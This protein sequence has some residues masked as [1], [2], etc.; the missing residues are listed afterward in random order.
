MLRRRLFFHGSG[1][2]LFGIYIVNV[3]FTLVTLG[4]Y[5]FWGKV[6]VRKYVLSQ[7]EIEGDRFAYHGT[8]RE[9]LIGFLKAMLFFVVPVIVLAVVRD[10]LDVWIGLKGLAGLLGYLL[11][12]VFIPLATVG[13]R[14]YR[15][16][17]SSW[18]GIRFSFRGRARDFVRIFVVGSV[19]S[20]FT[21]GLYYPFFDAQRHAFMTANS[22]FGNRRFDFDGAGR[23]LFGPFLLTL[24]LT[25]FTLGLIWFWYLARKR[26]YFWGH[27]WFGAARFGS[28]VTGWSLLRLMTGNLLLLVLTLGLAWP[29]A[30]VR[31]VRFAFRYLTLEGPLDLDAIQQ[32]AQAA[33]ATG[34]GLAG[35]LD[36]GGGFDLG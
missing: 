21:F 4:V 12:V 24:L 3:L 30:R 23:A 14:R 32:D 10:V 9:L 22:W 19:A 18:R 15:L 35:L 7:S 8:G 36:V 16:S 33:S 31:S 11:L 27:T 25:P 2:S 13:A 17:R 28:T 26:R 29:W 6:R 1:G 20:S 34:E 5:Y